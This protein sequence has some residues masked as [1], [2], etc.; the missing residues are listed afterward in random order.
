MRTLALVST[1]DSYPAQLG[2]GCSLGTLPNGTKFLGTIANA[3]V[4][5]RLWRGGHG[6]VTP[7]DEQYWPPTQIVLSGLQGIEFR[8]AV[9]G[10]PAVIS[11]TLFE[12]GDPQPDSASPF[13]GS[14][15][16]GGN[17]APPSLSV[18][19]ILAYTEF[20]APVTINTFTAATA[21]TVVG[22]TITSDGI[23]QVKRS[24]YL[25][26]L[27]FTGGAASMSFV[28]YRNGALSLAFNQQI[29]PDTGI[30]FT[31]PVNLSRLGVPPTTG[32]V[33]YQLRA[34]V[35]AASAAI[36]A[37]GGTLGALAPGYVLIEK[38][39]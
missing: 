24:Y 9:A 32:A 8:S 10:I 18:Y 19:Q 36:N 33:T 2:T 30:V 29:G 17:Y 37:G 7:T 38:V 34:F 11:G 26:S 6:Q 13:D 15:T 25:P 21:V 14:V 12:S 28:E 23:S 39:S 22:G 31:G 3:G 16:A 27:D 35:N 1:A 4:F 5:V 20:S